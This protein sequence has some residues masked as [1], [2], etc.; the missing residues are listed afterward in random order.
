MALSQPSRQLLGYPS[1][2]LVALE[3]SPA[4]GGEG[5]G[6]F[7]KMLGSVSAWRLVLSFDSGQ[8]K[9]WA[10]RALPAVLRLRSIEWK[11]WV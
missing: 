1:I 10:R 4:D 11:L 9:G 6:C 7:L 5:Q 3:V 8:R 2:P